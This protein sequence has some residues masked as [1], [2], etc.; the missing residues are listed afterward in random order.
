MLNM[1]GSRFDKAFQ[2]VFSIRQVF[3]LESGSLGA[4][5]QLSPLLRESWNAFLRQVVGDVSHKYT[6]QPVNWFEA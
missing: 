1:V 6:C 5:D 2:E 4:G 3:L